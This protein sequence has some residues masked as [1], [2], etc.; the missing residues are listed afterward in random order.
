MTVG[1]FH[2]TILTTQPLYG[3]R[4]ILL[5]REI[6]K[7]LL[8]VLV[9]A[10]LLLSMLLCMF[11]GCNPSEVPDDGDNGD[12]PNVP[13]EYED[14][15]LPLEDGYNQLILYWSSSSTINFSNS[16]M[17][18]WWDGKDGSGVMMHPCEYGAK[19]VINVPNT[20]EQVGFIV[21][22]DCSDPGGDS[23]GSANKDY[24]SDRF[25]VLTG[26]VT[27][28]Y[29]KSKDGN[30]Y[31]SDD[32]G[33]TLKQIKLFNLA[34]LVSKKKIRYNI[35]P[36]V[37]FTSLDQF[38]IMQGENE[39]A[40]RSVSSLKTEALSGLIEV[41]DSL[42]ITKEYSL[43]IEGFGSKVVIPMGYFSSDEFA[44]EYTYDGWLGNQIG[45]GST[46][47]RVW[48]PTASS[49]KLN[50]YEKG[51]G[52]EAY[53]VLDMN[54]GAKG[55]WSL[56]VEGV[57]H[58]TYYTYSVKTSVGEQEAVD[59]YAKSAG[60]NGDRGMVIDLDATDPDGWNEVSYMNLSKYT[61]AI[62]WEV[63]VR[64][65]S[66]KIANSQYKGKYLAFTETGLTNSNGLPVGVDYLKDLGVT[67]VQLM[68]VFDYA[69]VDE[70]NPDNGFN[71]GYDPK[72]YNVPEGS[73]SS[74]PTDGAVRVKEFKQMV[75]ALHAQGLSVIMDVVYNHTYD[76]NSSLNKIVPYYYYR[77]TTSGEN[78]SASGCGNDTAS[79]RS[80]Y[81]KFMVDSLTY[82]M[83]EYKLDG[84]R[85]DLMGLHDL[86]TMNQVEKELHAINPSAIIFG[87]GW[88]MGST[89]DGSL[90]ANQSQIS[91]IEATEGAAG[92]VGVF[93]DTVR[94]G[95]K[96]SVFDAEGAGYI[97]G[98]AALNF[99]AIKFAINGATSGGSWTVKNANV[100][101]YMS[102]HD[103]LSLWDKLAITNPDNSEEE[104]LAMNN[105]GAAIIMISQGVPF[106]QAGEEML[107][108]KGGDE[109]SYKSSDEVNNIDW[110]LLTEESLQYKAN[111]YYKGLIEMRKNVSLFTAQSGVE[112]N[113]DVD[114]DTGF[115]AVE[116]TDGTNRAMVLINPD[117]AA[118]SY[119]LEGN[120]NLIADG[121]QAG[122]KTIR[123][124][125][126]SVTVSAV[127]ILI[128]IESK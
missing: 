122:S 1:E 79:E 8:R 12:N 37:R 54:L 11:T 62:V 110:E 36:A 114:R 98:S 69:S 70:A 88:T 67:H 65:F 24:S 97:N 15:N 5:R 91:K 116:Y 76:A 2:C 57:G 94:D 101:N 18:I 109:N 83:E 17:W 41:E 117:N 47:F 48:A 80:M 115:M 93:N 63:H 74:D 55:V 81:R 39:V 72:N 51:N 103:N 108:S 87:E 112:H 27:E 66:N 82:W 118:A 61:D 14:Y 124:D 75:Q 38:K 42:D 23:W 33:V 22:T 45:D 127:S 44:E 28:I 120:W 13:G 95:L 53:K 50:L 77:Y 104:R 9:T 73:Y 121:N 31:T 19:M 125:S 59:P 26:R 99:N 58:G 43:Y 96:G 34:N 40:I 49:V 107:R 46:E 52:G 68:P 20:I 56:T 30:Q 90:Q 113:F 25:A 86:E 3:C 128:Y 92:S 106:M 84:F 32:G 119:T 123:T 21:R 16:D 111:R 71:W 29:L 10:M 100:I 35:T 126:G 105:L 78:T 7:K 6:V 102:C 85:F 64:D 4:I 60:L 89:S